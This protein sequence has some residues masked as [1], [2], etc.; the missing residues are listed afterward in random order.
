VDLA[1]HSAPL[2]LL[3]QPTLRHLGR[4]SLS[5]SSSL[6]TVRWKECLAKSVAWDSL[7]C[8]L[9]SLQWLGISTNM[10]FVF[11]KKQNRLVIL[12]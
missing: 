10:V 1:G 6:W 5:Q 4:E 3:R 12:A 11:F 9:P 2:E 8:L 7:T